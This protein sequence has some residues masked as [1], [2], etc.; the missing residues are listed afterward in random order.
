MRLIISFTALF[1]AVIFVQLGSG[2]VAPLDAISG[3]KLG[4][5]KTEVG[6]LG[7]AHFLGFFAGCWAAP[8]LMGSVGHVR[9]FAAFS[10]LGTI[11]IAAHMMLVNP[12]A[13]AVMRML[14]GLAVAGCYTVIEAWLQSSVTNETRGRAMASYRIVDIG[15]SLGAQLMIGVLTP[16]SYAS[17][18]L[19]AI[20]CCAA[21]LPLALTRNTEP[22]TPPAPRLRPRLAW[23]R[24]PLA[25]LA[26]VVSGVTGAAF[27]FV[28]PVYADGVG[29]TLDQIAA[30]LALY[31]LGGWIAQLPV[32]WLADRYDRRSVLIGLSVAALAASALTIFLSG[33]G[34]QAVYIAAAFFGFATLPIYSVAAAHAHDFANNSERV[35]LS[36]A[37][38]FLYALGAIASPILASVLIEAF[39]PSAM[40]LFL[41]TVHLALVAFGLIRMSARPTPEGRTRYTWVPRTSFQIGRLLRRDREE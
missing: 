40:F 3:L 23:D 16:S 25:A 39:G 36:A 27:R 7:S 11:G 29:L 37:L 9:S 30:F 22:E 24:S 32:G 31:V 12:L 1:L 4:F 19:L 41:S 38:M 15:A 33:A 17:Y 10:A 13:W 18:N 14:T 2:G 6:M 21:L 5:A 35:E 28:G 20:L 26:V 8:R 34:H